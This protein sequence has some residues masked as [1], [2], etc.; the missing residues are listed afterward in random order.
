[1]GQFACVEICQKRTF[2]FYFLQKTSSEFLRFFNRV[3]DIFQV[4]LKTQNCFKSLKEIEV[5][6]FVAL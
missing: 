1:M 5:Q 3:M 2:T 4:T 6:I